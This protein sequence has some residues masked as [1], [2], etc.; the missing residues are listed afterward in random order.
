MHGNPRAEL[1]TERWNTNPNAANKAV[2][3]VDRRVNLPTPS[4]ILKVLDYLELPEHLEFLILQE[5]PSKPRKP[6]K[7]PHPS[8]FV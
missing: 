6:R 3:Q 2:A 5:A 7:T 1:S 4:F 8:C